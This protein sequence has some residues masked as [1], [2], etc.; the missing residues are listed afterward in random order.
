MAAECK[1][2]NRSAAAHRVSLTRRGFLGSAAGAGA[3]LLTRCQPRA[4]AANEQLQVAVVGVGGR[5]A[6][7]CVEEGWSSIRQQTGGRIAAMC[8][9][10]K[11]KAAESFK[12][13]PDVP[14]YEDFRVMIAEMGS[15]LDA[16]V[17]ATPDHVHAA[18][19]ALALRAGLHVFCEKGLTRTLHE[20]RTLAE[21]TV[22]KK[23]STQMGNQGGYNERVIES[24]WAGR[25]GEIQTIHM[26]GG[27]GAGP[28]PK[29]SGEH[30]VPDYLNWDLWLGPATYRPYHPEWLQ[31]AMWRDFSCG[32]P[33]WWGAHLWATLYKA[34]KLETLWPID[35]KP[36]A[37][38]AK[39]IKVTAECCEVCE[40]TFPR[41]SIVHWDI[42]AR[43][44]LPPIRLSWFAGGGE[45]EKR[46][47]DFLREFFGKHPEWGSPDDKRWSSWT[48][49]LWFGT[50]G[51]MYTFG[52]GDATMALLPEEKFKDL[53]PPPQSLPRP[54][55][56]RFLRGWVDG[57]TKGLTPMGCF[58]AFSGPF[59]EWF[60]LANVATL[61]PDRP[62]EF[63]P[64]ACR[65]VNHEEADKLLRPPY[66]E[67]W[68][69]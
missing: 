7:F 62:L 13:Y 12:R 14:K 48:G 36:P 35:K 19:S 68:T 4:Y 69:L 15:K 32:H 60:L 24:V 6:G 47:R 33:G 1:G 46:R 51:A 44:D 20:A 40:L 53:P 31:H 34:M 38:G 56:G 30:Q 39:T 29:P 25:L 42:P 11:Q 58:N 5:G 26:W 9:V 22:E 61:F 63:D 59:T 27:G 2:R 50:E 49:N 43:M 10:N 18:P 8:D 23:L 65:I 67:G 16:V 64:V 55:P 28:R 66:R 45:V 21:L 54:L 41:S 52:H 37:A 17:V 57:M 3:L